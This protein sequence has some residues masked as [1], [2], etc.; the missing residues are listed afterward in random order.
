MLR[1]C[2]CYL[3]CCYQWARDILLWL[4]SYEN[5][6][7]ILMEWLLLNSLLPQFIFHLFFNLCILTLI[8]CGKFLCCD[9]FVLLL[10]IG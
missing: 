8:F 4:F 5:E 3:S 1:R 6:E 2:Y 7:C 10:V 9:V